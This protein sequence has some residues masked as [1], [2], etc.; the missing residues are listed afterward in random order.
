MCVRDSVFQ[1]Y[2][3]STT[4]KAV[5]WEHVLVYIG[6]AIFMYNLFGLASTRSMAMD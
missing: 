4:D 6:L 5:I 2:K 1:D 3:G